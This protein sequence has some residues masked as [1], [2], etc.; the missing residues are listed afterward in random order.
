MSKLIKDDILSEPTTQF[1]MAELALAISSVHQLNYFHRDLKP[2]NVLIDN[3][4]HIKLTDFG[5]CTT[6]DEP[7]PSDE[8]EVKSD[9]EESQVDEFTQSRRLRWKMRARALS[10]SVVGTPEYIAPEI[11]KKEGYNERCD[12][13][14]LGVIM[15]ECLCG[16]PPFYGD[17]PRNTCHQIINWRDTLVFPD[18]V[19][20]STDAEDCIRR[21]IT[22]PSLRMQFEEIKEHSFFQGVDWENIRSLTPPEVP[23]IKDELDVSRFDHFDEKLIPDFTPMEIAEAKSK[24]IDYTYNGEKSTEVGQSAPIS[25]G[26]YDYPLEEDDES[27]DED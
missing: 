25:I 18:D 16:Y 8:R 12:W 6:M 21:L 26:M 13:W 15:Y 1:Y 20:I 22:Y 27:A 9:G 10:Y 14:S 4:G 5:L 11:F 7:A 17:S 24:F 19:T 3:T 23:E 2:D